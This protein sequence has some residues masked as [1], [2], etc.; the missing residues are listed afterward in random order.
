MRTYDHDTT[1]GDD[2]SS[3]TSSQRPAPARDDERYVLRLSHAHHHWSFTYH[4]QPTS[5][6][7]FDI[8][9]GDNERE[10]L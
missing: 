5:F 1:L 6:F 10:S 8:G 4:D 9:L 7:R 2:L 3:D